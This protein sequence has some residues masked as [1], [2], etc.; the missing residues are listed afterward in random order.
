MGEFL[1]RNDDQA[2]DIITSVPDS[3]NSAAYGYSRESQIPF[4][5]GL[6]RNHYAGRTFIQ[7]TTYQREFGVRMKLHP[8]RE[9][10]DGRS[11]ILIDD[12]LVRG[13]TSKI[14]VKLMK[15]N[16]ASEVHFRLSSPEIR[17]P[18]FYGIDI[19]TEKE[20]ISHT[21]NPGEIAKHI[22]ADSVQFLP[23]ES[24]GQCVKDPD[25]FCYA[26]FSG[27]YPVEVQYGKPG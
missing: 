3:G 21:K 18:C 25:N 19:P 24:L 6:A 22:G 11:L 7:P 2:A 14:I 20:L 27:D 23:L 13:T 12:S 10:I 5:M 17:H 9:I 26:C 8:I 16:G 1:A 15:E 4:E